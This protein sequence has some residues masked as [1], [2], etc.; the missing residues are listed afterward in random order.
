MRKKV[1][2]LLLSYPKLYKLVRSLLTVLRW[3]RVKIFGYKAPRMLMGEINFFKSIYKDCDVIVDVGARFDVDYVRISQGNG[4]KYFLFEVNP[5]FF[6]KLAENLRE[7]QGESIVKENI[8]IGEKEAVMKY[9][10]DSESLLQSTTAIKEST[11]E[12]SNIKMVRLDDYFKKLD[13]GKIDFLKTDIEE[14]D[15]FAL[16][17]AGDLLNDC[18]YIQF[19]LGIGAVY[20][21]RVVCNQDYF[22]LLNE[23]FNL[24]VLQDENNRYLRGKLDV[25]LFE[26]NNKAKHV[27]EEAQAEG[28]GFNIVAMKK[29]VGNADL[30]IGRL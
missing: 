12:I 18:K 7:F 15:F 1:R 25:N 23:N 26:L 28:V 9:Y 2:E 14:Y 19:E 17:G 27:I 16:L 21:N 4:I 20:K 8:A 5:K 30:K 29:G 6:K 13:I 10:E 3:H 24:F 11:K 22:D